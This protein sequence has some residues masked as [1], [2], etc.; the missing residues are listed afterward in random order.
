MEMK[1]QKHLIQ[2]K[3]QLV[4]SLGKPFIVGDCIYSKT[5]KAVYRVHTHFAHN[6]VKEKQQ[7]QQ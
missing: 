2:A 6:F 7:Q 5:L 4:H 1:L 3:V